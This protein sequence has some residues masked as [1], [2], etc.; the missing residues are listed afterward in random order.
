MG[1]SI[2]A[3]DEFSVSVQLS[4]DP[5]AFTRHDASYASKGGVPMPCNPKPMF[6]FRP[7]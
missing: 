3:V 4:A 2:Q 5:P 6:K 7:V 1:E